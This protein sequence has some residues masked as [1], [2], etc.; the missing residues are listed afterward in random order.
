MVTNADTTSHVLIC[1]HIIE[2][3]S[4]A[5]LSIRR[6]H[7]FPGLFDNVPPVHWKALPS[8]LPASNR[9]VAARN[10][11]LEKWGQMHRQNPPTPPR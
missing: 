3:M 5:M 1:S 6:G 4:H 7:F 10:H 8:G 11:R 9:Q 2:G